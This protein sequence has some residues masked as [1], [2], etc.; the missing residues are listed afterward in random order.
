MTNRLYY[1]DAY[2]TTFAATVVDVTMYAER[3][4]LV[5]DRTFFYPTSGGQPNDTGVLA[6]VPVIDVVSLDG[7]VLHVLGAAAAVAAGASVEGRIDWPRRFDHMQQHSGQHLLSQVFFRLFGLETVSV[8]FG[9][10]DSTLDLDAAEVDLVQLD[11]AEQTANHV[12]ATALPIKAYFVN[13]SELAQLPLRRPP[14]VS[15]EIRIVEIDGY[16]YSACGGTHVHTTAECLPVKILKQERRRGQTRITFKC[17]LRAYRDYAQKHRVLLETANLYN[18]EMAAVPELAQRALEQNRDLQRQV[19][20][21]TSQLLSFEVETLLAVAQ[22]YGDQ[23][24]VTHLYPDKNVDALKTLASLLREQDRTMALLGTTAGAKLALVFSRSEDLDLNM[25]A[26]LRETLKAF[27]GGGGG[28]PEFAQGGG[29]A[30]EEGEAVL[31]Y[32]QQRVA[33]G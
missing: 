11:E 1:H 8:H 14:K 6:G 10:D 33:E 16:D 2:T 28:R 12:A 32:A 5:L 26:L 31:A 21:L 4:A 27:G 19:E 9:V 24:I 18:N 22:W 15:G 30:P 20:T 3:P 23:R 7:A 13:D 25:G 29:I 17:G